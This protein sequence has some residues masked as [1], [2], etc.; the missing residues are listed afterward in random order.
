MDLTPRYNPP[1]SEFVVELDLHA[2]LMWAGK[3]DQGKKWRRKFREQS[4]Q[5][6]REA[7]HDRVVIRGNDGNTL[8]S[9]PVA[10]PPRE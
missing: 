8:E 7:S 9:W 4:A 2:R 6:A 10:E 3:D 5:Q 1:M